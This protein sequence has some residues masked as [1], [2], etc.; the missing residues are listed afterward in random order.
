MARG[1]A[2]LLVTVPYPPPGT[3]GKYQLALSAP[4]GLFPGDK[5]GVSFPVTLFLGSPGM[6]FSKDPSAPRRCGCTAKAL[7][8]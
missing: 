5:P 2:F 8:L 1:M 3:G 7:L 6:A 4:R